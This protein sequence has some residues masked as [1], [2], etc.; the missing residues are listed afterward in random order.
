MTS[1]LE[2]LRSRLAEKEVDAFLISQA[3]NRRYL[4]G[5]VGSAGFL[6]IS[7]TVSI[8]ATDS[9][10]TEQAR[11]Q[12]PGFEIVQIKGDVV[13]WLPRMAADANVRKLGF[14]AL[15]LSFA[16]YRR[17][18][19]ALKSIGVQLV[20]TEGVVEA[21]RVIKEPPEL[22]A[23]AR[24]AKLADEAISRLLAAVRPGMTELQAT[25]EMEKFMR[26]NG[27]ET[28]PFELIVASGPNSALPHHRP[29]ERSIASGEPLLVDIGARVD[30]YC[31]D[32]SRTFCLGQPD[33]QF[34]RVYDVV[35]G[36]Q[37]T[38]M[39]T[40]EAGITGGQADSL[41]R[42]V[43]EQAG[44]GAN[45]GHGLGHGIGLVPHEEPRLG[46]GSAGVLKD[47]MVFTIEPGIYIPGWGGVRI[48]DTV[49]LEKGKARS[50]TG[51][52]KSNPV[53]I[54]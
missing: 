26:E 16:G 28:I 38:A 13:D 44:Q 20:P 53:I 2:R 46:P 17:L 54:S 42:T 47:D 34:A 9:R 8:L 52:R 19:D 15:A 31:S 43:I 51:C 48:E 7:A 4:S 27:S 30:G 22:A 45:F 1:R 37:L 11:G 49:V 36:A 39:S 14:E 33:K 23:I 35:L 29:T 10:Y 40:M 6:L 50:L 12:A 25:W 41:A 5:F 32:L 18:S 3:E 21:L 24:A